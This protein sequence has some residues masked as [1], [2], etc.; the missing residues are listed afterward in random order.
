MKGGVN[1]IRHH[2][3]IM[4]VGVSTLGTMEEWYER[5]YQYNLHSGGL[6]RGGISTYRHSGW[7]I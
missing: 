1:T 4:T 6:M 5:V 7:M 3:G 2:G